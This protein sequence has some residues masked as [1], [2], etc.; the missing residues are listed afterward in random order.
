MR[1]HSTLISQ[2]RVS[3]CVSD[4]FNRSFF[5]FEQS[6]ISGEHATACVNHSANDCADR[7]QSDIALQKGDKTK[8]TSDIPTVTQSANACGIRSNETT[9]ITPTTA[10]LTPAR[11]A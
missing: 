1:L 11:N 9:A 8:T 3:F 2:P 5:R 10:A 7:H 6:P 4:E